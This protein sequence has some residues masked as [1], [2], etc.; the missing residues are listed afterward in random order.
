LGKGRL[1]DEPPGG[2]GNLVIARMPEKHKGGFLAEQIF[3]P[4]LFSAQDNCA[5]LGLKPFPR[6]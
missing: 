5:R 6:E 3:T 1:Y 2:G 4:F